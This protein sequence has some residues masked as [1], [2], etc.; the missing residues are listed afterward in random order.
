MEKINGSDAQAR[1]RRDFFGNAAAVLATLGL[2]GQ[3]KLDAQ[4]LT[5]DTDILNFALR[6]ERLETNFFQQGLNKFN[7]SAF[8]SAGFANGLSNA[9]VTAAYNNV[10]QILAQEQSHVMQ[11]TGLIS[12]ANGTPP[13]ADCYGFQPYGTDLTSLKTVD[14]F[15]ATAVTLENTVVSAYAGSLNLIQSASLRTA[16]ATIATVEGRHAAYLNLLT[17]ASPFPAAT[18]PTLSA[19]DVLTAASKYVTSCAVFPPNANAGPASVSTKTNP[20]QLDATASAG[21][22]GSPIAA[23]QWEVAL[24]NTAVIQNPSSP[25]PTISFTGGPALYTVVLMVTDIRGNNSTA[26]IKVNY[27]G[28]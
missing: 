7:A 4:T 5:S 24:G 25:K 27:T 10:Q 8:A 21:A 23:Y 20:Y 28:S 9:Q 6:I 13:A 19:T 1:S 15:L 18:E 11:I 26:T 14:S 2:A 17:G 22:D 3:V 16:A 12:Q